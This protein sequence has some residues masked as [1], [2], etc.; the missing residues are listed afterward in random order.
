MRHPPPALWGIFAAVYFVVGVLMHLEF[1][2]WLV[3]Q[4]TL[5]W[6][7][8]AYT[9]SYRD[10]L[11][12][13]LPW[14]AVALVVWLVRNAMHCGS[15]ERIVWVTGYWV[16]WFGCVAAVD[17]WLTFSL[18]EYFHYPQY[19][20][21]TMLLAKAIDSERQRWP[22]VSLLLQ[23]AAL[24]AVDEMAQY[25]W[26]TVSYS[27]Y[28]DFNDVLVNTLAAALGIML[29]YGFDSPAL[30]G[31]KR[32]K[33]VYA[34]LRVLAVS[35]ALVLVFNC[36][37]VTSWN[38]PAFVLPIAK[39]KNDLDSVSSV[40]IF[41]SFLQRKPSQYYAWH[42]G[43]RHGYFWVLGPVGGLCL[44]L[45]ITFAWQGFTLPVCQNSFK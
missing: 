17:R 16:L 32:S 21:L 3:A 45:I 28:Y 6:G 31:R 25:L 10:A 7:E 33:L 20:I 44:S 18:A 12:Y 39:T 37:M 41:K 11:P 22:V 36:V 42:Q 1:S 19:A 8:H 35:G 5:Q 40:S 43:P 38:F 9:Y 23:T 14:V 27:Q 29:Y 30:N 15:R 34:G 13:L 2:L 4:R 26:V 24:G